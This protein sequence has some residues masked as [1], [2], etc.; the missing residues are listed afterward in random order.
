MREDF[1]GWLARVA[2]QPLPGGV[3]AAARAAAMGSALIVKVARLTLARQFLSDSERDRLKVT[4]G[5]ARTC[6]TELVGL[7]GADEGAYRAVLDT[8]GLPAGAPARRQAWQM[9]T[10]VPVQV[11]ETCAVLLDRLPDLSSVCWPAVHIDLQIGGWLLETGLRG[12][13]Q[14]AASNLGT[15]GD[16]TAAQALRDRIMALQEGSV[17]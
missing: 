17:D 4:L 6:Q 15:W 10:E 16:G 2:D 1:E 11:A 14:A 12:G 7:A 3:A 13:L 8:Q 9:A 5:L